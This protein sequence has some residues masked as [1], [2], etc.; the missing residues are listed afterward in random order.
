VK[1]LDSFEYELGGIERF[2]RTL[3]SNSRE[4]EILRQNFLETNKA[5]QEIRNKTISVETATA[6]REYFGAERADAIVA[7]GIIG[8]TANKVDD[9]K[10]LHA[11]VA[12]HLLRGKNLIG[13][14]ALKELSDTMKINPRGC[15]G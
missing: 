12:D 11:H 5:W 1:A 8:I 2:N 13:A 7:S 14:M 4:S 6:M 15:E 9:V 3:T 10:C